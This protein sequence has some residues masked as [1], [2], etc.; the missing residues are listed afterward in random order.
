MLDIGCGHRHAR[1][2]L[3]HKVNYIGLDNFDTAVAWYGSR[4]DLYARAESLPLA[5]ERIDNVL[6]LDVLE[7][8]SEPERCVREIHRVLMSQGKLIIQSPFLYPLHDVPL[9]FTRWTIYGISGLLEN[10]GFIITG[11][12]FCGSPME[13]AGMLFNIALCKTVINSFNRHHPGVLLGLLLPVMIPCI[14]L[15]CLL[16]GKIMPEDDF[17]PF[18]YR[19]LAEKSV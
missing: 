5:N 14:N 19:I 17:M 18:R 9:D 16:L 3:N 11:K 10:N 15:V 1:T 12:Q 8:V 6:L 7:H 4:P 13:T 2:Y